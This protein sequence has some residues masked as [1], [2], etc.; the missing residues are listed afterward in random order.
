MKTALIMILLM[1]IIG[2]KNDTKTA[3]KDSDI[4][5]ISTNESIE[6]S[7][8]LMNSPANTNSEKT[9]SRALIGGW[10][11]NE[12]MPEYKLPEDVQTAFD[13]VK[14]TGT[15]YVPVLYL[16]SQLVSGRNY[17][18]ICKQILTLPEQSES[19]VQMT[20]YKP[21]NAPAKITEIIPILN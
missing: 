12:D 5:A 14:E 13:E 6:K 20:I 11:V 2:C 17:M 7:D 9:S 21:L 18:L 3:N 16:G 10:K 1:S 8:V 4:E 19:V 15:E